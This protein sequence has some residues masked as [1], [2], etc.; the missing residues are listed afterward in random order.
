MNCATCGATQRTHYSSCWMVV[1]VPVILGL[2]MGLSLVEERRHCTHHDLLANFNYWIANFVNCHLCFPLF[3]FISLV[4][5]SWSWTLFSLLILV[6][7]NRCPLPISHS[8]CGSSESGKS[9]QSG[10]TNQQ[11]L[12]SISGDYCKLQNRQTICLSPSG[13]SAPF[14]FSL[15]LLSLVSNPLWC[16]AAVV[17]PSVP[18]YST[19]CLFYSSLPF[20]VPPLCAYFYNC[21]PLSLSP[22]PGTSLRHPPLVLSA[23]PLCLAIQWGCPLRHVTTSWWPLWFRTDYPLSL[24][25]SLL[26]LLCPSTTLSLYYPLFRSSLSP[27]VAVKSAPALLDISIM[28]VSA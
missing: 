1:W 24:Y 5:W 6:Q 23:L 22:F 12:K 9:Q 11:Q 18:N 21:P 15:S 19:V 25:Y 28:S 17:P 10:N 13:S 20:L 7:F 3:H 27:I 14:C 2:A 8:D 4:S 16:L 26:L